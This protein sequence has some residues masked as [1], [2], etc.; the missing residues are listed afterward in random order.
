MR[1]AP[2]RNHSSASVKSTLADKIREAIISH[3]YKPGER[4]NETSLAREFDVGR[5]MVRQAL[6]SLEEHGLAVNQPRRGMFVNSLSDDETAQV[7]SVRLVLEVEALKL[8]QAQRS[9]EMERRFETILARMEN[10]T[11]GSQWEAAELDLEFHR[12]IWQFSGNDYLMRALNSLCTVLFAR[13]VLVGVENDRM[14]WILSHH[15]LLLDVIQD[16]S[17]AS[18]EEAMLNHL[19]IGYENPER[20]S[21]VAPAK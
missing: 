21:S 13:R 11:S 12:A 19:K 10:W 17:N 4:L 8:C 2:A 5:I 18:P 15:R 6:A 3:K 16:R 14:R 20:F 9:A 7:N 1:K